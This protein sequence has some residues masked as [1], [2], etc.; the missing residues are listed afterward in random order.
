[1]L[2]ANFLFAENVISGHRKLF[3]NW[4]WLSQIANLETTASKK[5][6][7][8]FWH[9]RNKDSLPKKTWVSVIQIVFVLRTPKDGKN[10]Y[11]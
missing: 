10:F 2:E 5:T 8:F 1:M 11:A 7:T 3:R 4:F 6:H 9:F